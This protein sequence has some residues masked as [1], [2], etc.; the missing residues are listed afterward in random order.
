MKQG[1]QYL[2]ASRITWAQFIGDKTYMI[3]CDS[4]SNKS[5]PDQ[6]LFDRV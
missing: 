4:L 2:N 1:Q 6:T 3:F 5:W